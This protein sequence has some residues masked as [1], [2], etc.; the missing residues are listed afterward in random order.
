MKYTISNKSL[1]KNM[2]Q[3]MHIKIMYDITTFKTVLKKNVF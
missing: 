3:E 1:A 2:K